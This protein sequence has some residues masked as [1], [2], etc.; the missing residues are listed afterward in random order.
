MR[1]RGA[2][3]RS[4]ASTDKSSTARIERTVPNLFEAHRTTGQAGS[5]LLSHLQVLNHWLGK[6]LSFGKLWAQTELKSVPNPAALFFLGCVTGT[7]T[8][9]HTCKPPAELKASAELF[10]PPKL[11]FSKGGPRHCP[12]ADMAGSAARESPDTKRVQFAIWGYM[13]AVHQKKYTATQLLCRQPRS[14]A[15]GV[16]TSS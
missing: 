9:N 16:T 6:F 13:W 14:G 4:S 3:A 8:E 10:L 11:F 1:A 5:K 7:L 2:S 15:R 12:F